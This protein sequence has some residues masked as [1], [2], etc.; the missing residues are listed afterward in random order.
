VLTRGLEAASKGMQSLIEYQDVIANNI[1]NVNTT[2]FKRTT[3]AFKNLMDARVEQRPQDLE[4]I[5]STY[6]PVGTL[7][8][9]NGVD[10]TYMDFQQG[11]LNPTGSKLDIAINGEGFFKMRYANSLDQPNNNPNN[12]YYARNGHFHL[13]QDNYLVNYKGDYVTDTENRRIRIVRDP[14][15]PDNGP[16]NRINV[17][18]DL[19]VGQNGVLQLTH[20]NYMRNL[21]RIAIIDFE[22]KTKVTSVG[23]GKFMAITGQDPKMYTKTSGF[24]LSQ[25]NL[26]S[27]NVSTVTEMIQSV[28]TSRTYE[29]L[30]K[31]VKMQGDALSQAIELG[32]VRIF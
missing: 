6:R 14:D 20:P 28:N 15:N 22:D 31:M 25:G 1:A 16:D 4:R 5:G 3:M 2:G 19:L 27:A 18:D 11:T 30:A 29:T 24:E 17:Q 21:Q 26:E 7:S 12:Y 13:T 9:G 32:R 8:L 23:E 10:R